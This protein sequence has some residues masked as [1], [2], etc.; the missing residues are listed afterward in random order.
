VGIWEQFTRRLHPFANE[1][2]DMQSIRPIR[3]QMGD[4]CG[5]SFGP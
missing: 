4:L 2:D 3:S 5:T 1:I